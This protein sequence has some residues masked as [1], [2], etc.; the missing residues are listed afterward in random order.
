L[1]QFF[2][3]SIKKEKIKKQLHIEKKATFQKKKR[4]FK[5]KS[6]FGDFL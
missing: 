1:G 2:I 3:V 5:K 6:D 4:L